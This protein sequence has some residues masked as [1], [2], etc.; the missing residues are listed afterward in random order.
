MFSSIR[1]RLTLWYLLFFGG[2]LVAF[3]ACIYSLMASDLRARFDFSL[4]RSAD[5]VAG[6]F[7]QI[8]NRADPVS[9]AEDTVREFKFGSHVAEVARD[10][11]TAAICRD[12]QLLA[13][14][15]DNIVS[16]L[17]SPG[18]RSALAETPGTN[19]F[20]DAKTG[21]RLAILRFQF[22]GA[23]YAVAAL[24]PTTRLMAEL[25]RMRQIIFFGLPAALLLAA[26]GG[27]FLAGK[28]LKPVVAIS[29]QAEHISA[30]NLSDRLSVTTHD[31]LGRL[32]MVINALLARLDHSFRVMREFMADAA[33]ELKT[34]LAIVLAEADVSLS[35]P[36]TLEEYRESLGVIRDNCKRVARIVSDMLA[37]ARAD[38]GEQ[39][40][41]PQELYLNE[42]VEACCRS[43]QA[44]AGA[45]GVRLTCE[46]REDISFFGDE[47]LLKRMTVNLLDNAIRYT[48]SGGSVSVKAMREN[49]HARLVVEDTGIGI[50][51]DCLNRVFDRFFRVDK[52]RARC[53]GGSG[54][55]LS[56]VKLA[57]EAHGG[58]VEV[59]SELGRGSTFTVTLPLETSEVRSEQTQAPFT[60]S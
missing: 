48:P 11:L 53:E 24:E 50:P 33:H 3:S 32:A 22:Q 38:T 58:T 59:A 37:L 17:A 43:V 13:T 39:H 35:R 34:P 8:A 14:N 44:L 2:L 25:Q 10:R 27:F 28:S 55:G 21:N 15:G 41:H 5:A 49:A 6:Y 52:S 31:E 54:L 51:A 36:R 12:G 29:E 42:V 45:N 60:V 20:T 18:V 16:I 30:R 4:L 57:A 19:F 9:G 23:K 47:E 7:T 1:V 46:A 56:I 40:L 26:V